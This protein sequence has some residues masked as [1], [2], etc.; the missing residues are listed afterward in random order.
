MYGDGPSSYEVP[1]V[2]SSGQS[3]ISVSRAGELAL[4]ACDRPIN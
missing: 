1:H 3:T 2:S 4:L